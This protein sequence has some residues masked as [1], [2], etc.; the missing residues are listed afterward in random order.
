MLPTI[1]ELPLCMGIDI[2][3]RSFELKLGQADPGL[4]L[5]SDTFVLSFVL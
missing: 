3:F 5:Y 4:T 2:D 1:R